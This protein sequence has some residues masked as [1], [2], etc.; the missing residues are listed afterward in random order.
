MSGNERRFQKDEIQALGEP[1]R[2]VGTCWRRPNGVG[3]DLGRDARAVP[4][5]RVHVTE[6]YV[7]GTRCNSSHTVCVLLP[8]PRDA[9]ILHSS[10]D[11]QKGS[12]TRQTPSKRRG[13]AA[14]FAGGSALGVPDVLQAGLT[15]RG[16][17]L[18]LEVSRVRNERALF[19]PMESQGSDSLKTNLLGAGCAGGSV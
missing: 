11:E 2:A 9:S 17:L 6:C 4:L 7:C 14:T 13:E 8:T 18:V 3:A 15:L 1:C 12:Q 5:T 19:S 16:K 10:C